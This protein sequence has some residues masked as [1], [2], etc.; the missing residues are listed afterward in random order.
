MQ[1]R[2]RIVVIGLTNDE[3]LFTLFVLAEWLEKWRPEMAV[4]DRLLDNARI[5]I[6]DMS[7]RPEKGDGLD[8]VGPDVKLVV[9]LH[10]FGIDKL[11]GGNTAK[12]TELAPESCYNRNNIQLLK[13]CMQHG[14][15]LIA[16]G[17][18]P[19]LG[20]QKRTRIYDPQYDPHPE[21][22]LYERKK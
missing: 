20:L 17:D 18:Q 19:W 3:D 11:P 5:E 14:A 2:D 7:T 21:I 13:V 9:A 10:L 16:V 6:F 1:R 8:A 22:Y 15:A 12:V 4:H